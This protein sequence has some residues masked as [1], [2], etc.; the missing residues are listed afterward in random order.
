RAEH[1]CEVEQPA[2]VTGLL[3][4][5]GRLAGQQARQRG[6][7]TGGKERTP[8]DVG[9]GGIVCAGRADLLD[10]SGRTHGVL[11]SSVDG[12]T[13]LPTLD[14]RGRRSAVLSIEWNRATI[15]PEAVAY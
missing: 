10:C 11:T 3:R 6:R 8:V 14:R 12:D 7:A 15:A 13:P 1:I 9:V 5:V 4:R 2:L